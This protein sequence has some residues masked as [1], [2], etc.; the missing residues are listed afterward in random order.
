MTLWAGIL[1]SASHRAQCRR[2]LETQAPQGQDKAM[3]QHIHDPALSLGNNGHR[4][5]T[6]TH[7]GLAHFLGSLPNL[8]RP[9]HQSSRSLKKQK[10][11]PGKK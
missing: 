10:N 6:Q 4:Q 7:P 5:E 1:L 9:S 3:L 8:R 2:R 11:F